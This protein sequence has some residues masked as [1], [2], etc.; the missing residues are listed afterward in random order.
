[1]WGRVDPYPRLNPQYSFY[2]I[3]LSR[4]LHVCKDFFEELNK[5]K[6]GIDMVKE[7]VILVPGKLHNVFKGGKLDGEFEK[8]VYEW[9]IA[10]PGTSIKREPMY[11]A[12]FVSGTNSVRAIAEVDLR[13]SKLNK[14]VIVISGE[15]IRVNIPIRFGKDTLQSHKY[16]TFRK[17]LTHESTDDL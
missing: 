15:P 9:D 6:V 7:E 16:T 11:V 1:M 5:W 17:L 4:P 13:K 14:G 8:Y 2:R 3:L 10:P 12:Y